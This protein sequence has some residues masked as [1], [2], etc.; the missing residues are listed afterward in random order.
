MPRLM[1]AAPHLNHPVGQAAALAAA[2]MWALALVLFKVS[3]ER[4]A[5]LALNLFKNTIGLAL[6][7][8]TFAVLVPLGYEDLE[9]LHTL[10]AWKHTIL[11][12]SGVLGIAVA[13]TLFFHAL[14][15]IGVGLISIVDCTYTPF[16]ILFAWLMLGEQLGWWQYLG[17]ALVV[18]GV[19]TAERHTLPVHRTRGQIAT[20]MLLAPLAVGLMA[21]GVVWAKPILEEVSLLW[22][23]TLRLAGGLASLAVMTLVWPAWLPHWGVFRPTR[24]W[25]TAIPAS[26]LGTYLSLLLW[27]A[28]FKY[29]DASIAGVLN[30]TTVVFSTVLAAVFLKERLGRRQV[31]AL[32][33]ALGGVVLLTL[34]DKLWTWCTP[35]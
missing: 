15:L 34:G 33:L 18:V 21:F 10:S 7:L 2:L 3:G 9:P 5:P 25:R 31:G 14:N 29:T 28:G 35:G 19:F 12:L 32:V 1:S 8:A 30:Q 13:D 20:G 23:T 16:M 11:F 26:V 6:L 24:A 4:I 27:I 17:A 22:G